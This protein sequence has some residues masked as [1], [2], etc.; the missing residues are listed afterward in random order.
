MQKVL[1]QVLNIGLSNGYDLSQIIKDEEKIFQLKTL[2]ESG[3]NIEEYVNNECFGLSQLQVKNYKYL[4][5]YC[6]DTHFTNLIVL[7]E[8]VN[9]HDLDKLAPLLMKELYLID[10]SLIINENL[11]RIVLKLI[12]KGYAANVID[13]LLKK[14][15][16]KFTNT[17]LAKY[18]EALTRG[19]N[20]LEKINFYIE[21]FNVFHKRKLYHYTAINHLM[22]D[23][24][25]LKILDDSA[26]ND[27][28]VDQCI[29][30]HLYSNPN[31]QV[32]AFNGNSLL[33]KSDETITFKVIKNDKD[34]RYNS[35]LKSSH[36]G[37]EPL[38]IEQLAIIF[39]ICNK[40]DVSISQYSPTIYDY[41]LL[42]HRIE[43]KKSISS[44][45]KQSD[46]IRWFYEEKGV[47]MTPTNNPDIDKI[48]GLLIMK[49][50][51][52]PINTTLISEENVSYYL[53][54]RLKDID[55][56]KRFG[57]FLSEMSSKR[58]KECIFLESWG[59]DARPF[60][61]E[62]ISL[63]DL[64]KARKDKSKVV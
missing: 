32:E 25:I 54:A 4:K 7:R 10:Q 59:I 16:S 8:V 62:S 1:H 64:K 29:L 38:S 22:I 42:F 43:C 34:F 49:G 40:I 5:K 9:Y 45:L 41:A 61:D 58:L 57:M 11:A 35:F 2:M 30:D 28:Q 63:Y 36:I 12:E 27:A 60:I 48:Q 53:A 18:V 37:K 31:Q 50:Y 23:D 26:I 3:V 33:S 14:H 17:I 6:L 51:T 55:I 24:R 15:A 47:T 44:V 46:F 20:E 52:E 39:I 19:S 13:D 56:C 21:H